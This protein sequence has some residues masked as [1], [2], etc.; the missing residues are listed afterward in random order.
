M[1]LT[2]DKIL[3]DVKGMQRT[4]DGLYSW[5]R[6]CAQCGRFLER[7]DPQ[8]EVTCACGWTWK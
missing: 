6:T 1:R 3:D 8:K 5:Q 7:D 4:L 2:L